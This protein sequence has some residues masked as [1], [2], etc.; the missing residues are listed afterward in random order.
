MN[1]SSSNVEQRERRAPKKPKA[2]SSLAKLTAPR[3]ASVVNR[4]RLFDLLDTARERPIVWISSPAGSG[5][6]TLVASYLQERKLSSIW[7]QIDA[8]DNDPA[9]FFHYLALA[10]QSYSPR[11]RKVLPALTS[12]YLAGLS[13]FARN[14]FR[15]VFASIRAS[16]VLVFDNYQD[17]ADD[18]IVHH[19]LGVALEEIPTGTNVIIVSRS[20]VAESFT[21]LHANS[22]IASVGWD[23]MRMTDTE[24]VSFVE[25][26]LDQ[27]ALTQE[28]AIR[29]QRD[30]QGWAAGMVLLVEQVRHKQ[31]TPLMAQTIGTQAVFDYFASESFLAADAQVRDFLTKTAFL[32]T[33]SLSAA[34]TVTDVTSAYATLNDLARRNIFTTRCEGRADTFQ[35][36]P[37]FREFLMQRAV[38][39]KTPAEINA[40]KRRC[41]AAL[42]D[43]GLFDASIALFLEVEAWPQVC[44]L[45]VGQAK[46]LHAQ[47]RAQTLVMWIE[48]LPSKWREAEPWILYWLGMCRQ[49][50]NPMGAVKEFE[51]ALA[52]FQNE[53]DSSPL[54]LAWAGILESYFFA[55]T[56]RAD[57]SKW[58]EIYPTLAV[59]KSPPSTEIELTSVVCYLSM[60]ARCHMN[61]GSTPL[62]AI[63]AEQ[64]LTRV[65]RT[66]RSALDAMGLS[67]Y[68]IEHA[69][70]ERAQTLLRKYWPTESESNQHPIWHIFSH[71]NYG[72]PAHYCGT[73][74]RALEL[75]LSARS[76]AIQSGV[77]SMDLQTLMLLGLVQLHLG[78][79]ESARETMHEMAE[80]PLGSGGLRDYWYSNL[81]VSVKLRE[82]NS[83]AAVERASHAVRSCNTPGT[84]FEYASAL[85]IS[86]GARAKNGDLD[87]ALADIATARALAISS[88]R[89]LFYYLL[90]YTEAIVFMLKGDTSSALRALGDMVAVAKKAGALLPPSYCQPGDVA[91]LFCLALEAG[92]YEDYITAAIASMQLL[93]P[94]DYAS[95]RWPWRF[96][97]YTLGRFEIV[98]VGVPIRFEGKAQRRPLDLLKALIA[99][100]GRNV[101][102]EKLASVLWPDADGDAANASFTI[103]L[104]RLRKLL[105]CDEVVIVENGELS[106]DARYLW[107]DVWT[108]ERSVASI[109]SDSGQDDLDA[110][111]KKGLSYYHGPFLANDSTNWVVP[112]RERLRKKFLQAISVVAERHQHEGLWSEA[113]QWYERGIEVDAL[114]EELYFKLMTCYQKLERRS[115]ALS[116]YSRCTVALASAFQIQPTRKVQALFEAIRR[117]N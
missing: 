104:H 116:A 86:A 66:Y 15:D 53:D 37:L 88:P 73:P 39:E 87:G 72:Y 102:Q 93:P 100:G 41:A 38:S 11:R 117:S 24:S 26:R 9:S 76:K 55:W 77:R 45:I 106:L 3:L 68:Y 2:N 42:A 111:A 90:N 43:D 108:F 81:Y 101:S 110:H 105:G 56:D 65:P 46:M 95:E 34:N 6:T 23:D 64:L 96:R 22:R 51:K 49:P 52:L 85:R 50:L 25:Q 99:F 70:F 36:H 32:P 54:Y 82:G 62:H 35:Y 20:E 28:Q 30:A 59:G 75:L 17:I 112:P 29:V 16:G 107:V 27:A 71:M 109:R 84:Q 47:G 31:A 61:E 69:E 67:L 114:A 94:K 44:G 97:I 103:T 89:S 113:A 21:R 63:R 48:K 8:G 1:A 19:V 92:A 18:A 12:E 33:I 91:Q 10:V 7:Y 83:A 60:V 4:T 79:I 14:F 58:L 80:H 74:G 98:K 40:L 5:K 115:D 78:D 13:I 57:A